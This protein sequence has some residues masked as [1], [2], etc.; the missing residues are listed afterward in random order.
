[1]FGILGQRTKDRAGFDDHHIVLRRQM[2]A[3]RRF[4]GALKADHKQ[5]TGVPS[6]A[7]KI[8][9]NNNCSPAAG[10]GAFRTV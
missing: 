2:I 8:S 9:L 3:E 7:A 1:L 6:S 4:A 5:N 10:D